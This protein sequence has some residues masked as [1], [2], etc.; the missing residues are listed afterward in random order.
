M[1]KDPT[2]KV[3]PVP[4]APGISPKLFGVA[5]LPPL[6]RRREVPKLE[7]PPSVPE[8][9]E[10]PLPAPPPPPPIIVTLIPTNP[11]SGEKVPD[12]ESTVCFTG[13]AWVQIGG[14]LA[15]PVP[16]CTS[17]AGFAEVLPP[18]AV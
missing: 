8:V 14:A 18:R 13:L 5:P 3:P 7:S 9:A 6:A 17:L 15:V 2:G 4:P 1:S 16:V 12:P 11:A 10:A